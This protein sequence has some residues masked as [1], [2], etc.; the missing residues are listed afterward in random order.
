M[1]HMDEDG[2]PV[3]ETP[4]AVPKVFLNA[5]GWGPTPDNEP[6]QFKVGRSVLAPSVVVCVVGV[7]GWFSG[8]V[9]RGFGGRWLHHHR[10]C[11][12][13]GRPNRQ[14]LN[15]NPPKTI[16]HSTCPTAR[17]TSRT[18]WAGP[19]S[20]RSPPSTSACAVRT[21]DRPVAPTIDFGWCRRTCT[22]TLLHT[23]PLPHHLTP[24]SMLSPNPSN[25]QKN[26]ATAGAG[27]RE[28]G[29]ERGPP[30]RL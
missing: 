4:F 20:S 17:S 16:T 28:Q 10:T 14:P 12:C 13:A 24:L 27:G 22:P 26:R 7:G 3:E 8:W 1:A 30:L 6:E 9:G 19:R 15:L 2:P 29:D 23:R 21:H 18:G 11:A 5:G 25:K